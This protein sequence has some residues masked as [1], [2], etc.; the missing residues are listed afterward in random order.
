MSGTIYATMANTSAH[1]ETPA[2][3]VHST[4]DDGN[5]PVESRD[6]DLSAQSGHDLERTNTPTGLMDLPN[7]L[8]LPIINYTV[9][10]DLE[11]FARVN[12]R[13]FNVSQDALKEH[14]KLKQEHS[15]ITVHRFQYGEL[16]DHVVKYFQNPLLA[17]Y[18]GS[19][20][21]EHF[22]YIWPPAGEAVYPDY[23]M[24]AL[25]DIWQSLCATLEHSTTAQAIRLIRT[26]DYEPV[27][28]LLLMCLPKFKYLDLHILSTESVSLLIEAINHVVRGK[29]TNVLS[30]LHTIRL[31]Q[32]RDPS[33]LDL[34]EC[35]IDIPSV[36]VAHFNGMRDGG[37][38]T[39]L[40]P[41][42][43][44]I[45]ALHLFSCDIGP[46]TLH[47]IL[48]CIKQ[49]T[50]FKIGWWSYGKNTELNPLQICDKLKGRFKQSLQSLA[51]YGCH[52]SIRGGA[53]E[54]YYHISSFRAFS[55]LKDVC[56][57][58][59]L[60]F[61]KHDSP[62]ADFAVILPPSIE[63]TNFYVNDLNERICFKQ[64]EVARRFISSYHTLDRLPQ[65]QKLEFRGLDADSKEWLCDAGLE[66]MTVQ[67]GGTVNWKKGVD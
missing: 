18:V 24:D 58:I 20:K 57:N 45:T 55:N 19:L 29:G 41:K 37:C 35:M 43:S 14:W 36:R 12:V 53:D 48:A 16:A 21:F 64:S 49:L 1:H 62:T 23:Q 15:K 26:G 63:T 17:Q 5:T 22:G 8:L 9:P 59:E 42:S 33:N 67:R 7:E 32:E 11:S 13:I 47:S 66:S 50:V 2:T 34:F 6:H 4:S 27:M 25:V 56:V 51:M 28:P 46:Q 39:S 38:G 61:H 3:V 44:N 40:I 52:H 31:I 60:L 54:E 65:L 10:D 30:N